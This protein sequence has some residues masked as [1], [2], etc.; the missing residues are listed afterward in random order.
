MFVLQ[1]PFSLTVRRIYFTTNGSPADYTYL[2][3]ILIQVLGRDL[4]PDLIVACLCDE[5]G[6]N[7]VK[8]LWSRQRCFQQ[9]IPVYSV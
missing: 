9:R 3:D 8:P 6:T 1:L 7:T 2:D 4:V 5:K